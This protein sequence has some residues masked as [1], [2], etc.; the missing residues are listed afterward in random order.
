MKK[1]LSISLIAMLMTM[2]GMAYQHQVQ[3]QAYKM[4]APTSNQQLFYGSTQLTNGSASVSVL[5]TGTVTA[6]TACLSSGFITGTNTP[7]LAVTKSGGSITMQ[8]YD[9][10]GINTSGS[11]TVFY[12]GAGSQ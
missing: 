6:V 1:I 3:A 2:A 10:A 9:H 12:M 8:L 7:W 11:P 4:L 5:A